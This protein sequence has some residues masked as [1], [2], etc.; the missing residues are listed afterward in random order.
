M[1][2]IHIGLIAGSELFF[3]QTEFMKQIFPLYECEGWWDNSF[4]LK[5]SVGSTFGFENDNEHVLILT[6]TKAWWKTGPSW[7][8]HTRF[9]SPKHII[10][11]EFVSVGPGDFSLVSKNFVGDFRS[12]ATGL[13]NATK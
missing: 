4:G 6:Y 9:D 5:E 10:F 2:Q 3:D 12:I 13:H 8:S 7:R 11:E 1:R